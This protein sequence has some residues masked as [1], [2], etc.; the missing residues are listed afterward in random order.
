[1]CQCSLSTYINICLIYRTHILTKP[2][3]A[4]L[5][6]KALHDSQDIASKLYPSALSPH[7]L[8]TLSSLDR[9]AANNLTLASSA[10]LQG[11]PQLL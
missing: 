11:D 4:F 1:M 3:G 6:K 8:H 2:R 7:T 5:R 10:A 9:R